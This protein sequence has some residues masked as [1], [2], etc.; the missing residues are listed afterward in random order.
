MYHFLPTGFF[1]YTPLVIIATLVVASVVAIRRLYFHPFSHVPGPF[2]AKITCA[3]SGF[4][5]WR[6]TM[7]LDIQRCHQNY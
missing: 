6:G 5:S 2:L 3:Y 1:H 4:H 7:H